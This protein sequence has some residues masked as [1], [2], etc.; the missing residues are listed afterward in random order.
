MDAFEAAVQCNLD[1]GMLASTSEQEMFQIF[2]SKA[3][4]QPV[5]LGILS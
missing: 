2:H 5:W 1:G 4:N 3:R